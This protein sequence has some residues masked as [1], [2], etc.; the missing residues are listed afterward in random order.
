MRLRYT[1]SR[2]AVFAS[3]VSCGGG[4]EPTKVIP[5]VPPPAVTTVTVS[6]G[7]AQVEVGAT[8]TF[9]VDVRD[10]N[11]IV[12]A[13][14]TPAW[15][16]SNTAIATIDASSGVLSG[17][18]GGTATVTATI[19]GKSGSAIVTV[20]LLSVTSVS[21][22]PPPGAIF[23]SQVIPLP[24]ILKDRNGGSLA[25]RSIV[26]TSSNKRVATVDATG[27]V[28]ALTA[29]TTTITAQSEGIVATL[30][31]VVS[32]PAGTVAPSITAVSPATLAP[33]VTATISG[34]NFATSVA[35]NAVY[36][37]GVQGTVTAVT[38]TQLTATIPASGLPCLSTQPVS[39]E[40][41]TVSGTGVAKQAMSAA[42]PRN[43]AVGASFMVTAAGSIA[44]NELPAAGTYVISVFNASKS[45][46]LNASFEL[47]GL[48]GGVLAAKLSP[49]NPVRSVN[50]LAAPPARSSA[51]DPVILAEEHEHLL[52]LERDM[53][54]IRELGAPGKYRRPA[55]SLSAIPG[56]SP[57]ARS[58]ALMPVPMTVGLNASINFHFSSC[59]IASSV[60][61]TARVVYVGPKVI[62]LEDNAGVLAGKIDPDLIALARDYEDVSFPLL[63]NFGDPLAF[64][65]QT[66]A[67]GRIIILF[68]PQVN[69]QGTN[70]LGFVSPCDFFP[71]TASVNVSASNLAEIFYARAVTDTTTASTSLNARGGWKR[72]MPAT[73]IHESK[74]IISY[75][76]RFA[77]PRPTINEQI[78]LEEAT[79]Q[80]ASELY[81]RAIH[82]NAWRSN[83][84]YFGTL[85]CE[86][87]PTT[88]GCN[89]GILVMGNHFGFLTDYLQNFELKTIL[90][91]TDDND[92][93]GS[94][95]LFMR[96]L[97]DTYAG[98]TEGTFLRGIV[99]SVTTA[100]VDNVTAASGK[101]WPELLSQFTLMLAADDMPGIAQPHMESSWNLPAIFNGYNSDVPI[102]HPPIP[103][104]MRQATFGTSFLATGNALRG[105]GA[106]L[107]K[108]SGTPN[109]PSQLLDL[110]SAVGG[111]L[112]TNS[113]IGLAVLRLQ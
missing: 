14:K 86:V 71:P 61:V 79:A 65:A 29:G 76:E 101:S 92:I 8:T 59:A 5:V 54:I 58:F 87:R 102:L 4:G 81:G 25:G 48:A 74:H 57:N 73:L 62:V 70:L 103:L 83:A 113:T 112:A 68:T 22:T 33:G 49:D 94:A 11:G 104:V 60:P 100:G 2:L 53:Q 96:W 18:A 19:D 27:N 108:L 90:S 13:G 20:T 72:L 34:S 28:A 84:S 51:V 6:P 31:L 56:M 55:R 30:A 38:P 67:N 64:D 43:L 32:P 3:V 95:W 50:V 66:D 63:Q 21:I 23:P 75:A 26:W 110:H 109:A 10:Q 37:A 97:T 77:D 36:F 9:T 52:R 24:V 47:Q 89:G 15:L 17:I 45:L 16:S 78:W 111:P 106:V 82:G 12:V 35:S 91:G 88:A 39:V 105:G 1:L 42:T 44:C 46:G 41:T 98:G 99:K 85:D 80:L 69:K 7:A 93:Y 107:V 40:V